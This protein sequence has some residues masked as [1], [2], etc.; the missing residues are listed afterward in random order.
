[1]EKILI[2]PKLERVEDKEHA[3]CHPIKNN[4]QQ[5]DFNEVIYIRTAI[6]NC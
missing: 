3:E 2:I 4:Y 5:R 6:K 1:M